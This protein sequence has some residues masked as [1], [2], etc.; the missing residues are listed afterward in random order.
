MPHIELKASPNLEISV[1]IDGLLK[2]LVVTLSQIETITP[3][4]IK[5]YHTPVTTHT[6]GEEAPEEFIHCTV[7]ILSGRP[8]EL[9]QKMAKQ[10]HEVM[11]RAPGVGNASIS[12]ELR[13]M[14]SLTYIK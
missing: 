7:S 6:M 11:K 5:A 12:L 10:M 1:D 14:D 8:V 4:A 3:S 9:R 13:E 2:R